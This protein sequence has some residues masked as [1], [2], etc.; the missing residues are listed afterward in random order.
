MP[1]QIEQRPRATGSRHHWIIYVLFAFFGGLLTFAGARAQQ[2]ATDDATFRK[3]HGKR[4]LWNGPRRQQP[5]APAMT[6]VAPTKKKRRLTQRRKDTKK[7]RRMK[8]P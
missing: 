5:E 6:R 1:V 2:K 3:L 8:L 4:A 7:G